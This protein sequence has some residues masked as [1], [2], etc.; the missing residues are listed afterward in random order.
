VTLRPL[1]VVL[2]EV[3]GD[4]AVLLL[5]VLGD[6]DQPVGRHRARVARRGERARGRQ[7]VRVLARE[8]RDLVER[9]LER[10]VPRVTVRG[11]VVQLARRTAE[12]A[13]DPG[14]LE[15]AQ[16][17]ALLLDVGQS[18]HEVEQRRAAAAHALDAAGERCDVDLVRVHLLARREDHALDDRPHGELV[19]DALAEILER[20]VVG[21]DQTGHG[22]TA[23]GVDRPRRPCRPRGIV[24]CDARDRPAGDL[25]RRAGH[26]PVLLAVGAAEDRRRVRHDEVDERGVAPVHRCLVLAHEPSSRVTLPEPPLSHC[27]RL[28][29]SCQ[30]PITW[31]ATSPTSV[32]ARIPRSD[33]AMIAPKS[34]S[35]ASAAR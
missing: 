3:R 28:P 17:G 29:V 25:D 12:Q 15:R 21:A 31:S 30:R 19:A 16:H 8:L 2:G 26:D 6:A 27:L 1:G 14:L 23:A 4:Q 24:R 7:P 9:V 20:V 11:L 33:E 22:Q 35:D 34:C 18:D 10:D 5:G 32:N 13:A